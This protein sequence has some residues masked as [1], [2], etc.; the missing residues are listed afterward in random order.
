MPKRRSTKPY[1]DLLWYLSDPTWPS[2]NLTLLNNALR[3]TGWRGEPL[4]ED[5]WRQAVLQRLRTIVWERVVDDVR[6]FLE[7]GVDPNVLNR[8]NLERLLAT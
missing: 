3:Q 5:N 2:P 6:P 8:E 4:N 1:Y 7:P